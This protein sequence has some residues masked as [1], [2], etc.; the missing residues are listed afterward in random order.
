[1]SEPF[2]A[3]VR[4]FAGN[5]APRGWALCDGQILPI[6]QNTAL[7][8]LLG[9]TYGGDGRVTF[10]LPDLRGR[11][12]IHQGSGPGLPQV[13]LG[14]RAGAPNVTLTENQLP[15]HGH[16][17]NGADVTGN[18]TSMAGNAIAQPSD[19]SSAFSDTTA[20]ATLSSASVGNTGG[21]Q[22]VSIMQP[23]LGMNYIIALQGVFPS[24]N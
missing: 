17:L 3:E 15:A 9:T 2:L 5:F 23:F 11:V 24:R 7:F 14:E 19:G 22:P 18:Q 20:A 12:A 4:I 21:G 8:S 16:P 10:G 13:R 1:M 6:A